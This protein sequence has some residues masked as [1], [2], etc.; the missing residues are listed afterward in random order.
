MESMGQSGKRTASSVTTAVKQRREEA[1]IGYGETYPKA[2]VP[3]LVVEDTNSATGIRHSSQNTAVGYDITKFGPD[4]IGVS[5]FE[6]VLSAVSLDPVED[7]V[8]VFRDLGRGKDA[9]YRE[10]FLHVWVNGGVLVACSNNPITGEG[11]SPNHHVQ[12]G[13]AGYMGVAG[14][15]QLVQRAVAHI[16]THA[17][18]KEKRHGGLFF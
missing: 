7:Y 8:R 11:H 4:S 16:D 13:H 1:T 10:R 15:E 14:I 3:G 18:T 12:Q 9:N 2:D 5:R 17:T 6:S